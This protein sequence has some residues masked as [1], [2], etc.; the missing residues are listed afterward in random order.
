MAGR[1]PDFAD[2]D[3]SIPEPDMLQDSDADSD[4]NYVSDHFGDMTEISIHTPGGETLQNINSPLNLKFVDLDES[5]DESI[6]EEEEA[7]D[8]TETGMEDDER[9]VGEDSDEPISISK[10]SPNT[11]VEVAL[12]RLWFPARV[13]SVEYEE[14][15]CVVIILNSFLAM[16][17]EIVGLRLKIHEGYGRI[18]PLKN[19]RAPEKSLPL[20]SLD[21]TEVE[22]KLGSVAA[23][24]VDSGYLNISLNIRGCWNAW[25]LLWQKL[26]T[27]SGFVLHEFLEIENK[28][29][30]IQ[31]NNDSSSF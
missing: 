29:V 4:G 15:Y 22:I 19:D 20:G 8:E 24:S 2:D 13:L 5:S 6:R 17:F 14:D 25:D 16:Y 23:V 18:K 27:C 9:L 26:S 31:T 28:F 1:V 12:S 21:V 11:L 10:L 3:F 7:H 30:Q